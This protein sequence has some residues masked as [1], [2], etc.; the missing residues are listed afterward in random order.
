MLPISVEDIDRRLAEVTEAIKTRTELEKEW[1]NLEQQRFEKDRKER[2]NRD[3]LDRQERERQAK[4][5]H[6]IIMALLVAVLAFA[7]LKVGEIIGLL[8]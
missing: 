8:P 5:Q 3:K 6:Q 7:G 2:E 4:R 1:R